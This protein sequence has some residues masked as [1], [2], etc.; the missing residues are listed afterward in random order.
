MTRHSSQ[1]KKRERNDHLQSDIAN[2]ANNEVN[3][4]III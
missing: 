2:D 1:F 4:D 3:V